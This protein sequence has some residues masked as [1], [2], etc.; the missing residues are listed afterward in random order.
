MKVIRLLLYLFL[1]PATSDNGYML[2]LHESTSENV[3][4][5]LDPPTL[6]DLDLFKLRGLGNG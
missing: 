6:L 3:R 1:P 5:V 4:G 2:I